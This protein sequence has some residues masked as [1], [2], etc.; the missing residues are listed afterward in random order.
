MD[1]LQGYDV[2]APQAANA[3]EIFDGEWSSRI[4]GTNVGNS[5]LFNDV[6]LLRAA[7]LLGG[8]SGKNILELGP[9]EGAHT[10]LMLSQGAKNILAIEANRRA[11]LKCLVMKNHFQMNRAAFLLGDF[12]P[13]LHE[14]I[15]RFDIVIASGVLYHAVDPVAVIG[16]ICRVADHVYVWSHYYNREAMPAT[17]AD[18]FSKEPIVENG[19][20]MWE[21]TYPEAALGWGGFCGG[22]DRTSR[23]L[24]QPSLLEAF[25]RNSFKVT[26]QFDEPKN[27][28][29]G[30]CMIF[31][32]SRR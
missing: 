21:R 26:V 1:T 23:W 12:A 3:L 25:Q 31:V 8:F 2:R 7:P 17:M 9:L 30:P 10:H 19:L 5:D 11:F 18:E 14:T 24:S 6:H 20:L 28:P 32:A 15:D 16:D 4:P 13:Y 29:N 22:P 27:H